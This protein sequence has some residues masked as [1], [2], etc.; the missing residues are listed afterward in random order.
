MSDVG[1]FAKRSGAF[2][3]LGALLLRVVAVVQADADDLPGT[4]DRQHGRKPT[5]AARAAWCRRS[6]LGVVSLP[7]SLVD[8]LREALGAEHVITEPEQLR[9]YECDGLTGHRAVPE[10][11]VLPGSTEDVQTVLRACHRERV[12]FVARGAG[13]GLSG[14]ATP[15]AGGV[16][17]SLARMN[18]ILEIDLASQRVVVEPG[19]ANLDVTRAVAAR[20]LL[21]RARPVEPAGLHDRRQRRRELRRRALPQVRL[22]GAPRHRPDVRPPRRRGRRAR[23][24]GARPG[25]ARPPRRDRRLRGDARDRD[26]HHAPPR[27][28][29]ADRPDAAR[30]LPHD[31]RG[32]RRR[33]GDRRRGRHAV[34]DRDDG[35]AHDR[36][37]RARRRARLP[38]G[39]RRRAP[40]RARRRRRAGRGRRGRGRADLRRVRRVRDPRRDERRRSRAPL[41][42]P[43]VGVRRDGPRSRPTTTCRTASSRARGCPRCCAGSRSSRSSTACASGT[44]STPATA[45][46]TRSSSTTRRRARRSVRASSPRRSSTPASTRAA[47]SPAS[48]ASGWTRRARCRACSPSATSHVFERL[49]RAFDPAGL[50]NPGKVIPTPRLCGEVPGPYRHPRARE[51]RRCRASLASRR[52]RPLSRRAHAEGRRLRIGDDLTTEGLTRILEHDPGDL[53]CTV[54]AGVRLSELQRGARRERA[55]GSR[56]THPATRRSA[57]SSRGT[58]PARCATASARR[59]TSSSARRSSSRTG[60]SRTPAARS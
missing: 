38:G 27:P 22:H 54:E 8:E 5:S 36:G 49:R 16:V 50:C 4:L 42:G 24:E 10:L 6:R 51:D 39:R 19:V 45:T 28:R 41:E 43:Q 58:S 13:T 55:S 14:G 59:A 21:L 11:V 18:R 12:P 20:R 17:V 23:R 52:R 37:G 25:R 60:R 56:S 53:T 30:R 9:V 44:S 57:R 3:Q 35:P 40:R 7:A 34:R 32:G 31:G 2:G 1:H 29:A 33:L 26:A 15:V 48:T 46:S 47:R